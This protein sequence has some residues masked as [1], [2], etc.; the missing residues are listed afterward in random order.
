MVYRLAVHTVGDGA[1]GPG[2]RVG[3]VFFAVHHVVVAVR[4]DPVLVRRLEPV[5]TVR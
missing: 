3:H 2:G 4:F 5:C 1:T